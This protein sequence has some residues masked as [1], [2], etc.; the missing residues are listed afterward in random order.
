[1][2]ERKNI[3]VYIGGGFLETWGG[4]KELCEVKGFVYNTIKSKKYPIIIGGIGRIYKV[5]FKKHCIDL[6]KQAWVGKEVE[7]GWG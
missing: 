3:I 5:P 2:S 1:M 6:E 7:K 4:L